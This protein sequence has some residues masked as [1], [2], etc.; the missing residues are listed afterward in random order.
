MNPY[1][2]ENLIKQM[3]GFSSRFQKVNG[4]NTHYVIGGKGEPL[5]LLPGWPQ[6][7][8]SYHHIMPFLAEK[9]TVIAVDLR[10]M[11]DS[12]KPEEGYTKKHMANDIQE[13][14]VALGY[15]MVHVAGHDIGA[16]VAYSFAV[17]H[18]DSVNKL[19]LLDTPP[20]DENM[21]RLPMLP[22]GTPVYPWWVAFNQLNDLPAQLL[23]GRFG[24]LLDHLFEKLLVNKKAINDFDRSVYLHHYNHKENIR[25]A[26]AWYQTFGEDIVQQKTYPKI[27]NPTKGIASSASFEILDNFLSQNVFEHE[28][29]EVKEC[30]HFLQEEKPEQI[31]RSISDFLN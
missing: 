21:Y 6:T 20:P 26:N 17:N 30:G 31:A 12:D 10:G 1:T 18:P 9:Y 16:N 4:I 5:I 23:E 8:W 13:L 25:A 22:V 3:P 2:T 7:W 28:M 24:L 29:M 19:I 27:K 11:G 15:D 14:I